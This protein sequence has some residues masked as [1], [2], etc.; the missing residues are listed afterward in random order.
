M[1]NIIPVLANKLVC[2]KEGLIYTC[3]GKEY[4]FTYQSAGVG[5]S[6]VFVS[7]DRKNWVWL[8]TLINDDSA[9]CM[10]TWEYQKLVGN[11]LSV[12]MNRG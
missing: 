10:H 5:R 2:L 9:V 8:V 1:S 7:N 12:T 3:V 6:T 11:D 4:V